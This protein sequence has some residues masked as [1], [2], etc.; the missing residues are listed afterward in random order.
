[1]VPSLVLSFQD[2]AGDGGRA[3]GV[4]LEHFGGGQDGD[5]DLLAALAGAYQAM[6][7]AR[8]GAAFGGTVAVPARGPDGGALDDRMQDGDD[9]LAAEQRERVC[10]L[11]SEVQLLAQVL[12]LAHKGRDD[13]GRAHAAVPAPESGNGLGLRLTILS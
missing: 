6:R 7:Q 11:V 10:R 4:N 8:D 12:D 3:L 5:H 9:L 2:A 1:R 13:A